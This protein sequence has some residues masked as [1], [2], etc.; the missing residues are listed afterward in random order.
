LV[1]YNNIVVGHYVADMIVNDSIV[2][3]I[4][5]ARDLDMCHVA[6]CIN[7]LKASKLKLALLFNFGRSKVQVKRVA[8]GL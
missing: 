5:V 2:V 3:E 7:Y 8:L 1:K 4:K 6:Q